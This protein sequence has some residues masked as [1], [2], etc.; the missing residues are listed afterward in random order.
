MATSHAWRVMRESTEKLFRILALH[1][2]PCERGRLPAPA[3]LQGLQFV[4]GLVHLSGQ[5]RLVAAYPLQIGLLRQ[6][7]LSALVEDLRLDFFGRAFEPDD[8]VARFGMDELEELFL[9]TD[10]AT[11]HAPRFGRYPG[12]VGEPLHE[13]LQLPHAEVHLV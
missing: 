8:L 2:Q 10:D 5:V 13:A 1:V 9:G 6:H 4:E 12:F 11:V 7:P 3:P